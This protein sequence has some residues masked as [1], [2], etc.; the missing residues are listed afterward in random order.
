MRFRDL[1]LKMWSYT[2][3]DTVR[4]RYLDL[5][6]KAGINWL[7]LGIEAGNREV[8]RE[9]SKGTFQLDD[10]S[11]VVKLVQQHDIGVQPALSTQPVPE[12]WCSVAY[13]E[14]DTQVSPHLYSK[15]MVHIILVNSYLIAGWRNI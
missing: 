11:S 15:I 5:F 12:F 2:R 14:L 8:R 3:V 4:E 7:A 9:V 13:F 6:K 1:K 10:I